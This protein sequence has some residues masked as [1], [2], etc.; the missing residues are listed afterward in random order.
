[1]S[2]LLLVLVIIAA[3]AAIAA[4]VMVMRQARAMAALRLLAEQSL[5]GTRAEA[6]TTRAALRTSDTAVAERIVGLR[7][8]YDTAMEQMRTVLSR[9]QGDL[10][11]ALVEAQR[12]SRNKSAHSSRPR[13]A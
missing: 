9:D 6:E 4:T 5:A 10:R 11:L 12:K 8:A 1:M 7:G 13:A 2:L 3:A